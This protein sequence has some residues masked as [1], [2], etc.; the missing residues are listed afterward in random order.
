[1][2]GCFL[3]LGKLLLVPA[4]CLLVW[5]LSVYLQSFILGH[6]AIESVR[7][8]KILPDKDFTIFT[9]N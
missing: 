6:L 1:M 3:L 8:T 5:V 4:S 2:K 9:D 7:N